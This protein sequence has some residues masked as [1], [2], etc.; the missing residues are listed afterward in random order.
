MVL[1]TSY[2]FRYFLLMNINK[3]KKNNKLLTIDSPNKIQVYGVH[4]F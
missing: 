3:T 4:T 1:F 2:N